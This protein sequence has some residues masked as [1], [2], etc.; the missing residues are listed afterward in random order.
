MAPHKPRKSTPEQDSEDEDMMEYNPDEFDPDE[1]VQKYYNIG[2]Y[3][4]VIT[5]TCY[6]NVKK[7]ENERGSHCGEAR[8]QGPVEPCLQ[9]FLLVGQI[10]GSE[11]IRRVDI[12]CRFWD[13]WSVEL[14]RLNMGPVLGQV[15]RGARL[16]PGGRRDKERGDKMGVSLPEKHSAHAL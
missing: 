5:P 14:H 10:V 4:S 6:K 1:Y 2:E 8:G 12:K 16:T 13:K 7:V 9:T 3:T 15:E 11:D